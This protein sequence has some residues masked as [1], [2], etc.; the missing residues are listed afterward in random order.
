MMQSLINTM[1][2]I[3]NVSNVKFSV[4]KKDSE[5]I[6]GFDLSKKYPRPTAPN[7]HLGL[8]VETNR[9]YLVPLEVNASTA[10]DMLDYLKY[11]LENID[12]LHLPVVP[13]IEIVDESIKEKV[14]TITLND[15]VYN[16]YPLNETYARYM[17]DSIVLSMATLADVEEIVLKT[18]SQDSGE[19]HGYALGVSFEPARYLNME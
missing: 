10:S 9:V 4:D 16:A 18:E 19:L 12:N 13:T 5:P 8:Q 3:E 2:Y 17:M 15:E 1:T 7:A 11:G 6:N 14:L